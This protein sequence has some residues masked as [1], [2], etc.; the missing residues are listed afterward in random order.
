LLNKNKTTLIQCPISKTGSYEISASVVT[1]GNEAFYGCNLLTAITI[2]S[3]VTSISNMAFCYCSGLKSITIPASVISIGMYTFAYCSGLNSI[4]SANV[5]PPTL[6]TAV[7]YNVSTSTCILSVPF[8]SKPTYQAALQWKNFSNIVEENKPTGIE[9][10]TQKGWSLY[11]NPATEILHINGLCEDASATILD[12]RGNTVLTQQQ[13]EDAIN[14]SSL[15]KGMYILKI[16]TYE[17][18]ITGK[19]VKE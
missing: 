7:F 5:T 16:T 13:V 12:I 10:I 19:F 4:K 11:P 9:T 6:G 1:I 17:G 2:P 8:N 15:A 14:I 3:S 18:V